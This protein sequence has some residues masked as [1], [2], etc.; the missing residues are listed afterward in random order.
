MCVCVCAHVCA[1]MH[2]CV[3]VCVAQACVRVCVHAACTVCKA[4]K[5]LTDTYPSELHSEEGEDGASCF[6]CTAPTPKLTPVQ[7][8]TNN[9]YISILHALC[10]A[11][12]AVRSWR[13]QLYKSKKLPHSSKA[14]WQGLCWPVISSIL[15]ANISV[16]WK[17]NPQPVR[18]A[19]CDFI[20]PV[21][22]KICF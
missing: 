20:W 11:N 21:L 19:G 10:S 2:V 6:T 3:C 1:Y 9:C 13:L 14:Q 17:Q 5:P 8:M 15:P 22:K 12:W 18:C 7:H 4:F 16:Y